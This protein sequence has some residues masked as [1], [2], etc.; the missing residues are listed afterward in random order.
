MPG[1]VP[2]QL[3]LRSRPIVGRCQGRGGSL[4]LQGSVASAMSKE[5]LEHV[6][7]LLAQQQ[8]AALRM[9]S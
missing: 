3:W 7:V 6:A 2:V 9:G 4:A 5:T 1:L 8:P